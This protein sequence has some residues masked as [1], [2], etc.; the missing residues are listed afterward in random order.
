MPSLV[1]SI[2]IIKHAYHGYYNKIVIPKIKSL[3]IYT[4]KTQN[5]FFEVFLCFA[6]I[7]SHALV[8]KFI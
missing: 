3:H 2:I 1:Y 4:A 7:Y 8:F 6:N 5:I